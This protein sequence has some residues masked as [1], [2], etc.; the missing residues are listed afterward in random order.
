M[1][2]DRQ[3]L[4]KSRLLNILILLTN[5]LTYSDNRYIRIETR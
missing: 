4:E 3:I 2:T 5:P 1:Q